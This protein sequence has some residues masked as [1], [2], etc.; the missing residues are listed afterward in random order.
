MATQSQPQLRSL[1]L[2]IGAAVEW[3]SSQCV[4][5]G[6]VTGVMEVSGPSERRLV[7][8][9]VGARRLHY[10]PYEEVKAPGIRA[11]AWQRIRARCSPAWETPLR[12]AR[13]SRRRSATRDPRS[14]TFWG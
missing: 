8:E 7:V 10:V 11:G 6:V 12:F 9:V 1:A 3:R 14:R 13:L 5:R 2:L 4:G